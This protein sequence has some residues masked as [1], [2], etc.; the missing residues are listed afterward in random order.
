M[1]I[2]DQ[3]FFINEIEFYQL[4]SEIYSKNILYVRALPETDCLQVIFV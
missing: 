3:L 4:F 2:K 1:L